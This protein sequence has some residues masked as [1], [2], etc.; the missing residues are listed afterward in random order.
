MKLLKMFFGKCFIF[1]IVAYVVFN[2]SLH[3]FFGE[4]A[5]FYIGLIDKVGIFVIVCILGKFLK[6]N[7]ALFIEAFKLKK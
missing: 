2:V 5:K 6:D 4:P 1:W 3:C 7:L